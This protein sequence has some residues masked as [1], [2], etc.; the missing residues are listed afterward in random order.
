[1][2]MNVTVEETVLP[3]HMV[4]MRQRLLIVRVVSIKRPGGL[5]SVTPHVGATVVGV[6]VGVRDWVAV[7]PVVG[8]RQ[9]VGI[10]QSRRHGLIAGV[11]SDIRD[12]GVLMVV[13]I[14]GIGGVGP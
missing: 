2:M 8:H 12:A 5:V 3:V 4:T 7:V 9:V 14:K 1:M 6:T 10:A 11:V 13:P